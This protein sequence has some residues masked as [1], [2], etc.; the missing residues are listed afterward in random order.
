MFTFVVAAHKVHSYFWVFIVWILCV[1]TMYL[2]L[3]RALSG[4]VEAIFF[5]CVWLKER[6]VQNGGNCFQLQNSGTSKDELI[7]T[8]FNLKFSRSIVCIFNM[9]LPYLVAYFASVCVVVNIFLIFNKFIVFRSQCF[10]YLCLCFKN[11]LFGLTVYIFATS[12]HF[13]GSYWNYISGTLRF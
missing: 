10:T 7:F 13:S 4:F 1:F 2:S 9:C 5:R 6:F 8:L 12:L 11:L 3:L